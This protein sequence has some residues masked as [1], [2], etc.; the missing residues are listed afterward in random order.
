MPIVRRS[1]TAA[2]LLASPGRAVEF[3]GCHS[4]LF[5]VYRFLV[6]AEFLALQRS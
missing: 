6:G 1:P 2:V 3:A 5:A 4:S